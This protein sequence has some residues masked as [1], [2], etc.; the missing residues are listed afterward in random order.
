MLNDNKEVAGDGGA[1]VFAALC[2]EQIKHVIGDQRSIVFI[3]ASGYGFGVRN[4]I[5]DNA[6]RFRV[7]VPGEAADLLMREQT[8]ISAL[9]RAAAGSAP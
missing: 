4:D 7:F 6:V 9:M 2:G 5:S 3:C 1:N 8:R